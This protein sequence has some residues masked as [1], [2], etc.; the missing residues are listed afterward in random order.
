[1]STTEQHS[2]AK[3][4]TLHLLPGLL[5]GLFYLL[6]GI[7]I[8]RM[9]EFPTL[10]GLILSVIFVL[11]PFELGYLLYQSRKH[12]NSLLSVISYRE[13]MPRSRF[14]VLVSF[15]FLWAFLLS[16]FLSPVDEFIRRSLFSWIPDWFLV[17]AGFGEYPCSTQTITILCSIVVTG[18]IAPIVEEIY[19]RGYLLPRISRFGIWAPVINMILFAFYHFW[20]PWQAVTRFVFY[21]P[22]VYAV[23]KKRNIYISIWEH[24]L[25]NTT[26]GVLTLLQITL[27]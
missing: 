8:A 12:G 6:V 1:M 22:V 21:L 23:W 7:P 17:T 3:S 9:I 4:I 10:F 11:V 5:I 26:G 27:R 16:S 25:G 19:F 24:T 14:V 20:S 18:I 15:L 13:P 2:L